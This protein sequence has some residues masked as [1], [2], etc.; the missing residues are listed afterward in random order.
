[1]IQSPDHTLFRILPTFTG[2]LLIT[3][4][5]ACRSEQ[6]ALETATETAVPAPTVDPEPVGVTP[7]PL[8]QNEAT[9]ENAVLMPVVIG[10]QISATVVIAQATEPPATAMPEPPTPMP[11]Y[12]RYEGLPLERS[13]LGIQMHIHR[14]DQDHLFGRP[15][16]F[17]RRLGED[18]GLMEALPTGT[19]QV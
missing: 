19:G 6:I 14:E 13:D 16:R 5:I 9:K 8:I 4:L 10:G 1:M 17:G 15:T 12:L 18:P 3:L 2:L 7:T 11:A